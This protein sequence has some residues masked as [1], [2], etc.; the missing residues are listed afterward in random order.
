MDFY[1]INA[2]RENH[3]GW[4]LLRAQ[5]APLAVS[6]FIKA[7][8]GPNQRDIGRQELIDHLDDVLFGLRRIRAW[9]NSRWPVL[10]KNTEVIWSLQT[11]HNHGRCHYNPAPN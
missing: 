2:L 11:G 3:A 4:S 5:N 10:S 6:F 1:A 8:T 9:R 7:F